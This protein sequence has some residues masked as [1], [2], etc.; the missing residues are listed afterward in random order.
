VAA[1]GLRPDVDGILD[2]LPPLVAELVGVHKPQGKASAW[3][4]IGGLLRDAAEQLEP[5]LQR[6]STTRSHTQAAL[7]GQ[8]AQQ[9]DKVLI[10]LVDAGAKLVDELR[11]GSTTANSLALQIESAEL[12][13][14]A[15]AAMAARALYVAYASL[16]VDPW[17]ALAQMLTIRFWAE[18]EIGKLWSLAVERVTAVLAEM[19]TKTVLMNL[20]AAGLVGAGLGA[21]Q[22]LAIEGIEVLEGHRAGIDVGQVLGSALSMGVAGVAGAAVGHVGAGMLGAEGN[23]GQ[24]L[25]KG[26]VTGLA[27]GEAANVAGTLAGG[28]HIGADT[29]VGG[30]L[31]LAEGGLHGVGD[32]TT[33]VGEPTASVITQGAVDAHP[34]RY[35]K[36]PDGMFAWPGEQAGAVQDSFAN[37]SD[38]VHQAIAARQ[39]TPAAARAGTAGGQTV[40]SP[41]AH[42]LP[43]TGDVASQGLRSTKTPLTAG[44]VPPP[45][46]K[47]PVSSHL[48]EGILDPSI[49]SPATYTRSLTAV[50]SSPL[51]SNA[52]GP[53]TLAPTSASASPAPNAGLSS[54]TTD[55]HA[56]P[57][58]IS[59]V[60][61]SIF[62]SARALASGRFDTTTAA[63]TQSDTHDAPAEQAA[64]GSR[65][66][67]ARHAERLEI[68]SDP[69]GRRDSATA[70][71]QQRQAHPLTQRH[72]PS[73]RPVRTRHDPSTRP[74]GRPGTQRL[75]GPAR[76]PREPVPAAICHPDPMARNAQI[77][78][79]RAHRHDDIGPGPNPELHQGRG[80]GTD[81]PNT[82]DPSA[83]GGGTGNNRTDGSQR[84]GAGRA[85]GDG[86]PPSG[87]GDDFAPGKQA[88][89]AEDP[90]ADQADS[91][92]ADPLMRWPA[93]RLAGQPELEFSWESANYE[94]EGA[95][96]DAACCA[97]EAAGGRA[98]NG[99]V[100]LVSGKHPRAVIVNWEGSD[101]DAALTTAL[102]QFPELASALTQRGA[103]IQYLS[104]RVD[105]HDKIQLSEIDSPEIRSATIES[106]WWHGT[107][108]KH[109]RDTEGYWRPVPCDVP[110]ERIPPAR[111]GSDLTA[112][113]PLR[114]EYHGENDVHYLSA[115]ELEAT[116]VFVGP[117]G[118]L[119]RAVDGTPF[120][121][122]D[123]AMFAMDRGGNLHAA[124][125]EIDRRLKHSSFF[126]GAPVAAAGEIKVLHGRM[127]AI[128]DQNN[129]YRATANANDLG[130][131]LLC[132]RGL[133]LADGFLRYDHHTAVRDSTLTESAA[134]VRK[135]DM[136]EQRPRIGEIRGEQARQPRQRI[137]V[138]CDRWGRNSGMET[139][140]MTLCRAWA[141]AGHEVYVRVRR[142]PE[143]PVPAGVTVIGP[144]NHPPV[145]VTSRYQDVKAFLSDLPET[146]DLVIGHG[147]DGGMTAVHAAEHGY[148][149]AK[150]IHLSHLLPMMRHTIERDPQHGR[151]W[152]AAN[153]HIARHAHLVSGVGPVLAAEM[154]ATSSMAGRASV[155]ELRPALTMAEQPRLP[156]A[157]APE[158]VL[159]FGR[160]DDPLKGA[161]VTAQ[162]V[163]DLRNSGHDT[164]RLVAL[165]AKPEMLRQTRH[166]LAALV[167][168]PDAVEVLPHTSD[169][170]D[171]HAIT[172]QATVIIM[173]SRAESFGL[174]AME[175]I[176]QGV[177]VLMPSSSG[178][179]Q[180]L[181]GLPGYREA[182]NRFNLVE[183]PFGAPPS[184]DTW[185]DRLHLVLSD[186]PAAWANA[187]KLQERLASFTP[188]RSAEHL[189]EAARNAPT[190]PPLQGN[191]GRAR[192]KVAG[193]GVVVHPYGDEAGDHDLIL[194]VADAMETNPEVKAAIA[195]GYPVNFL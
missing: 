37:T 114:E 69:V 167:G 117:D 49:T 139:L 141:Q 118:R 136:V 95:L 46:G 98:L 163:R 126:A 23:L 31:G 164:A 71:R 176:E 44:R 42:G 4:A 108:V 63:R 119:Y 113:H 1:V 72:D 150:C 70:D 147:L 177:P 33:P 144:P 192:V 148:P 89:R 57:A 146:V 18:L 193:W 26:A 179:G 135:A 82:P 165:G 21:G 101:H 94:F 2:A 97:I 190:G 19:A 121:A 25:V 152:L 171:L 180:F 38:G 137:L 155:H 151:A 138:F 35:E 156:Q 8:T 47:F 61:T 58:E 34:T 168:K 142:Q 93:V 84:G 83:A 129:H 73:I 122:P 111:T 67:P 188:E 178:A 76:D 11:S 183:Q 50:S 91:M 172:R 5:R 109:W 16:Q 99:R 143:A 160:T 14:V 39:S 13:I 12:G 124:T 28:G 173:P 149:N 116:R 120:H 77:G 185:T 65:V 56:G 175:A 123:W 17:A 80:H 145:P 181:A 130:V 134:G 85:A 184:V 189:V 186:L 174:V 68:G 62:E 22:E 6:L 105:P 92:D 161:E 52:V 100:G 66:D 51:E 157:D 191:P 159:L 187:R 153:I 64:H 88:N 55:P 59:P 132:E 154:L 86:R 9:A 40:P 60:G 7:V 74:G 104:G 30:A 10:A 53:V 48:S 29:F 15:I 169:P 127:L 81:L 41:D 107:E 96:D 32:L 27:S 125:T 20:L 110:L 24:R 162:I 182:A 54:P 87:A 3:W 45:T 158:R 112:S 78:A 131:Q 106:G 75:S 43:G 103:Q 195:R 194:A 128:S 115:A 79:I 140:N 170:Q 133:I 90:T 36:Q 102:D 166:R